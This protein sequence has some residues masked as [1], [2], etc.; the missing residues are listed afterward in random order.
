MT[1]YFHIYAI[2]TNSP[3]SYDITQE[4]IQYI[5]RENPTRNLRGLRCFTFIIV[6]IMNM[7][8]IWCYQLKKE[9]REMSY[10]VME[11]SM[12]M[13]EQNIRLEIQN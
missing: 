5:P 6:T 8:I 4:K 1:L 12:I 10:Q 13:L 2:P 7:V 11:V 3:T 9:A